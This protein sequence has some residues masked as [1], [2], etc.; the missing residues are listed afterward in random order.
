MKEKL[1]QKIV[2][3]LKLK[4]FFENEIKAKTNKFF[5]TKTIL[6]LKRLYENERKTKTKKFFRTRIT[7]LSKIS[8]FII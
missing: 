6:K 8:I 3:K 2:T 5:K 7:L 4:G 1:K